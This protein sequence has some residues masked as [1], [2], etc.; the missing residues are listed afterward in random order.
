MPV[1]PRLA[2]PSLVLALSA[3]AQQAGTLTLSPGEQARCR[4]IDLKVGQELV[5][6]LPS[7]PST[8]YRWQVLDA[9]SPQLSSL[10]PEVYRNPDDDSLIGAAGV[11]T[12][13]FRASQPGQA[14]LHLE[15]LQPWDSSTPAARRYDC[16]VRV[17]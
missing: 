7:N 10:G 6:S 2:L 16:P 12:W 9:A 3:C 11:S 8:G 15:Y 1:F 4:T 13:R 17:R 14:R 5:L